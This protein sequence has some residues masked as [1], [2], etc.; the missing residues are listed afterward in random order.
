MTIQEDPREIRRAALAA[1][2][3]GTFAFGVV[4]MIAFNGWGMPVGPLGGEANSIATA[5][6]S[7]ALTSA[8]PQ[9][10]ASGGSGL[11]F[12]VGY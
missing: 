1:G 12:R 6:H 10:S 2:T 3:V 7:G 4:A 9:G 5:T 8:V 11:V